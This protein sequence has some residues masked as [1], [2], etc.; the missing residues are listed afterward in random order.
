MEIIYYRQNETL[1]QALMQCKEL[2]KK[3][4]PRGFVMWYKWLKSEK[5]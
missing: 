3:P 1:L 5:K 2:S 4:V